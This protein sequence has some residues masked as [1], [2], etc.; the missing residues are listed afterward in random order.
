M[1][2]TPPLYRSDLKP[3]EFTLAVFVGGI[4]SMLLSWLRLDALVSV[5][6]ALVVMAVLAFLRW[7][8]A[9][10]YKDF[11][12]LEAFAEDIYLLGYLLTLAALL[13]LAPRLMSDEKNLFHIA[14]VKL[15]TT[16]F[17]LA[18]MMVFRQTARR[19][20]EEKEGEETQ[21]F[22]QQQRL[23]SEAVARLNEGADQLTSKLDEIV[24][25]FDPALLEPLAEWSN[26]AAGSF[27]SATSHLEAVP[28]AVLNALKQLENV[29]TNLEQIKTAA[30]ELTV[31]LGQASTATSGLGAA[32][33]ALE[34]AGQAARTAFEKFGVQAEV[35]STKLGEVNSGL[36]VT[37][38]DLDKVQ[39]ALKK[40]LELHAADPSL[41]INRLVEALDKSAVHTSAVTER[42]GT[43][44]T[45][46]Q[47]ITT[48]S[49]EVAKRM[50]TQ[51][52]TPL[53]GH[54]QALDRVQQQMSKA[55]EQIERVA[56]QLEGSQG[57][58]AATKQ[59]LN[60]FAGLQ[61]EMKQTNAHFQKLLA[62]L[63][64][65]AASDQKT[66]FFG[67]LFGGG[68]AAPTNK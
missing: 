52:G 58:G 67:K 56:R 27:S 1:S 45:G 10:Q 11:Q 63:D 44:N 60:Q 22:T 51:V 12:S 66:G 68:G 42:V 24:H 17:G 36:L 29:S 40:L 21:K 64:G 48:A 6:F 31:K 4:G 37:A 8:I 25:R 41:P 54:Q 30:A 32:V 23:F 61:V 55:G 20:A 35:S 19:W 5:G 9:R 14:G 43:L 34:P 3:L 38:Q 62:R 46:L 26:R 7:R 47:S 59:L 50:E 16:V 33:S 49:H 13:G 65:N 15:V 28:A 57:D 18:L 2:T 53:S 39:R